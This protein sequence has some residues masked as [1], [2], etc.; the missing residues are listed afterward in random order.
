MNNDRSL[1]LLTSAE[2]ALLLGVSRSWLAK[3]RLRGDGPRFVKLGRSVR[4]REDDVHDYVR[5]RTRCSTS[6]K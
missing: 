3:S 5:R 4:Y 6:A 1:Q 2:A